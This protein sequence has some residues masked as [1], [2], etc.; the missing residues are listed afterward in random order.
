MCTAQVGVGGNEFATTLWLAEI[1]NAQEEQRGE[2][3]PDEA[4]ELTL[5]FNHDRMGEEALAYWR[6]GES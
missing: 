3:E 5:G 6:V 4:V 2:H 1:E